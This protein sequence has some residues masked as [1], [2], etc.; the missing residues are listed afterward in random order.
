MSHVE[1]NLLMFIPRVNLFNG[2]ILF[3]NSEGET[4]QSQRQETSDVFEQYKFT[5]GIKTILGIE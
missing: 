3:G 4:S 5:R 1:F 2:S